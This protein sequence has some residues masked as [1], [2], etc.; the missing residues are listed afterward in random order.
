MKRS[1]VEAAFLLAVLSFFGCQSNVEESESQGLANQGSNSESDKADSSNPTH[2]PDLVKPQKLEAVLDPAFEGWLDA[3]GIPPD[4]LAIHPAGRSALVAVGYL[5]VLYDLESGQEL[6]SWTERFSM[7][8]F[9]G[10]GS[11][12]VTLAADPKGPYM[13]PGGPRISIP[14]RAAVVWNARTGDE[15]SRIVPSQPAWNRSVYGAS[16]N[17]VALNHDGT[18]LVLSNFRD[19]FDPRQPHGVLLFDVQSGRLRRALPM[20]LASQI[21]MVFVAGGK[22]LLVGCTIWRPGEVQGRSPQLVLTSTLW[23]TRT[24]ELVHQF[25]DEATVCVSRDGQWIATGSAVKRNHPEHRPA[26]G[27]TTTLTIWD[28]ST[29][30]R[31]QKLEHDSNLRDFTFSPDSEKLL[32]SVGGALS[33]GSGAWARNFMRVIRRSRTH[34]CIIRQ[35]AGGDSL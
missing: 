32:V 31:V 26:V 35:T 25:P 20:P 6:K 1:L 34:V 9:S 28:A 18:Q 4:L 7:A 12:L 13:Y 23:D 3:G 2:L 10:D 8:R 33:S 27:D 14:H 19:S 15:I 16:D 30:E 22:R 24:G 11:R 17:A 21:G 5:S 29:G